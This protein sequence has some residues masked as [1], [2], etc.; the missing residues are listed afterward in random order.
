MAKKLQQNNVYELW[1][2]SI[3][4]KCPC[5][6]VLMGLLGLKIL[7]KCGENIIGIFLTV[8]SDA[9]NAGDVSDNDGVVIRLDEVC[10]TIGKLAINKAC[11]LYQM[12]SEVW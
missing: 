1:K 9:F 12:T 6:P 8:K 3:T 10:Y 2:E 11:G 5:H 4:V 7:L